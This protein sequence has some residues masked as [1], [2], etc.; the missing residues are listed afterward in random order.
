MPSPPPTRSPGHSAPRAG[1]PGP[2]ACRGCAG[3]RVSVVLD[4]GAVPATDHFPAPGAPAEARRLLRMT[5][6]ADCAL[7]QL[8][9]AAAEGREPDSVEPRAL[10]EQAAAAVAAVAADGWL[11]GRTVREFASPHGGSW[12]GELPGLRPVADGAADVVIDSFGIM[13]EPDQAAAF[14]ARAAATAATGVLL[15]Q[16]H[17]LAAIVD[18]GQWNAL[19]HGHYAYYTL[20]VLARLLA[21]AGMTVTRA[22]RFGLYGGTVLLAAVHGAAAPDDTVRALAREESARTGPD[23]VRGL[24]AAAERDLRTVRAWLV[25]ER[26]RR[27]TVYAY[28]AAS[29]AVAVFAAAGLDRTLLAGVA[30]AAP[31]KQGRRMPGTDIP[32]VS[33]A[34]LAGARPDAV[35]LT[36]PDLYPEVRAALPELDGR[37]VIDPADRVPAAR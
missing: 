31:A 1:V 24:G 10:R 19:R 36:V 5:R 18:G 37:W 15:L 12:L 21:A 35:W 26:A 32:I 30:D 9:A 16:Y 23:A 8:D 29:R 25:D 28:G 14:A 11:R 33:P 34:E 2:G 27:R 13:H 3:V 17:S 4:L 6:C 22:W 20:P 7:V